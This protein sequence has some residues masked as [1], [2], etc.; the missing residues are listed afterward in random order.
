M[1]TF[2]QQYDKC[3]RTWNI[4][5]RDE[6][7]QNWNQVCEVFDVWGLDFMGPIPNSHGNKFILVEVDYVSK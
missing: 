5:K 2:V 7:L 4:S 1:Q 6:M 3:Q